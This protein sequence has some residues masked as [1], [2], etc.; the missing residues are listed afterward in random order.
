M[1]L[2]ETNKLY[3]SFHKQKSISFKLTDIKSFR[4]CKCKRVTLTLF[5]GTTYTCMYTLL[6]QNTN[7][8]MVDVRKS[9]SKLPSSESCNYCQTN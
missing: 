9:C 7:I 1:K 5:N 6:K 3:K 8:S 4:M 2:L